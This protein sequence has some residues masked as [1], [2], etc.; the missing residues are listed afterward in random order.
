M[1]ETGV[2]EL[3]KLSIYG[4]GGI[5]KS[6][7]SSNISYCLS[8]K[9]YRVVHIGCDPKHDSTRL[10]LK[11][12]NQT[13]VLD[14]VRD[15]SKDERK[16]SDVLIAGAGTVLCAESGGPEP[17]I[18][19]AG[20]GVLTAFSELESLGLDGIPCHFRI[21]DVLGDVVC[22][23]FAVPMREEYADAIIIVTSG[24]FMSL[25]AANNIMRG[26]L[27]FDTGRP[28]L[29]GLVLNCRGI[30]D[31]KEM[32]QRFADQTGTRILA[33]IPRSHIFDEAERNSMTAYEL[34]PTS[35]LATAFNHLSETIA[36]ASKGDV[37][38]TVPRPLNDEM[39]SDLAA[40][41][42]FVNTDGRGLPPCRNSSLK[43]NAIMRS[44]AARGAFSTLCRM[45]DCAVIVHGPRSCGFIFGMWAQDRHSSRNLCNG[46]SA[47]FADN[48]FCT[49]IDDSSAVMGDIRTLKDRLDEAISRRF[50]RIFVVTCCIPAIVGDDV[51]GILSEYRRKHDQ[52]MF[53][54]VDTQG[55]ITGDY[56]S[57]E[58]EAIERMINIM[59]PTGEVCSERVNIMKASQFDKVTDENTAVLKDMMGMFGLN[60]GCSFM[61]E[62]LSSDIV[63][64]STAGLTFLTSDTPNARKTI[65]LIEE[66]I[67]SDVHAI[68]LP[69]GYRQYVSWLDAMGAYTNLIGVAEAEKQRVKSEY[70]EFIHTHRL[71]GRSAI[72]CNIMGRD[73]L[74]IVELLTDM[75]MDVLRVGLSR[76]NGSD[77]CDSRFVY[78]YTMEDLVADV[79]GMHPDLVVGDMGLISDLGCR[80]V[81]SGRLSYGM[82][83][84]YSFGNRVYNIFRLPLDC[85]GWKRVER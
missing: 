18:G 77:I 12:A 66:R 59:V 37:S 43:E 74:W 4:K 11:G 42:P 45:K 82:N 3:F 51:E 5:G 73:V 34:S 68:V 28:R 56:N 31:E 79:R 36:N 72:I 70:S 55:N 7:V 60:L 41:R 32:V 54:L 13:T 26:L 78:G 22:G 84:A 6:T 58:M 61:T 21:H 75:G 29:L 40:G 44:C 20:R 80:F 35:E 39:L 25:Y 2:N 15:V 64:F 83:D 65:R 19:C 53:E 47:V 63:S 46:C 52:C 57:G 67:G 1:E 49:D 27:N 17:G 69:V 71:N 81:R 23:G 24:E 33:V 50:K 30:D 8:S 62:G 48:T 76:R 10:L 85:E 14:Y 16:L 9:G 38:L